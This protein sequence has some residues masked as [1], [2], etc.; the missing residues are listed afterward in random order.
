MLGSPNDS[1]WDRHQ[2][3]GVY[4]AGIE[5]QISKIMNF[6]RP[7]KSMK[8]WAGAGPTGSELD[9]YLPQYDLEFEIK[10]KDAPKLNYFK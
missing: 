10:R 9:L 2:P 7:Y 8:H 1:P 3:Y 5:Q 4:S 6:G